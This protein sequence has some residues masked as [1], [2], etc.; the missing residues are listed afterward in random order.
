MCYINS[1]HRPTYLSKKTPFSRGLLVHDDGAIFVRPI[2]LLLFG[3]YIECVCCGVHVHAAESD[4]SP[5]ISWSHLLHETVKGGAPLRW[6][7][8]TRV[9]FS[10]CSCI[11]NVDDYCCTPAA[12]D[13][14][15][16]R[17]ELTTEVHSILILP[18]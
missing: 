16:Q 18:S 2:K 1:P 14:D 15:T 10:T 8:L 5:I 13:N 3:S 12:A 4:A 7:L 11:Y 9:D 6:S 17:H